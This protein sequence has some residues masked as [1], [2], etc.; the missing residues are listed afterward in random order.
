MPTTL[1]LKDIPDEVYERLK[2]SANKHRRSLNREAIVCLES[3]LL[4]TRVDRSE[5]LARARTLRAAIPNTEFRARD[6]DAMK[7]EGR[8]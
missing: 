6:I 5:R 7:R 1:T 3:M 4:P 2:A 8:R